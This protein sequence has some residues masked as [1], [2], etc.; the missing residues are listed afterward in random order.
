MD[1][2]RWNV[3]KCLRLPVAPGLLLGA[4]IGVVAVSTTVG[5]S[6]IPRMVVGSTSHGTVTPHGRAVGQSLPAAPDYGRAQF[7]D[8]VRAADGVAAPRQSA[9]TSRPSYLNSVSCLSSTWCMAV[10]AYSTASGTEST[11]VEHWN[12]SAWTILPSPSP[13]RGLHWLAGVSCVSASQCMAVGYYDDG[14]RTFSQTLI[15][16]WNGVEWSVV[17]S[18]STGDTT[19]LLFGVSCASASSC[20]AV[21]IRGANSTDTPLAEVWN[22][23]A[24]AVVD[25]PSP[26]DDAGFFGVSCSTSTSCV[27]VGRS[28]S[29][30]TQDPLIESWDGVQWTVATGGTTGGG[31]LHGVSCTSPSR[32]TAVGSTDY[33]ST[34]IESWNGSAWATNAS[35]SPGSWENTLSSVS[36]SLATS[37]MA[38]GDYASDSPVHRLLAT[39]FDGHTWADVSGERSGDVYGD[40]VGSVSC[41]A[42][43][44]C[45]AVGYH[46][47]ASGAQPLIEFWDGSYWSRM[48]SAS[49][50]V[51]V[52]P[53]VGMTATPSGA[54]YWLTDWAGNVSPHGQAPFYGSMSDR[55]LN[56]PVTHIVAAPDG[57]GYWLVASDGGIFSFGD[58]QFFGSM[59]GKPLNAPVVDLA[60]TSSGKGYWLVASDGGVFAFGDAVFSGS[61]GGRPLQR[62]VVGIAADK[63]TGG[64]WLVASDGGIFSFAAPFLGSTGG[65]ALNQPV[66]SMASTADGGG[67][68]STAEDGGVFSYGTASF[69]GSMGGQ[70]LSAP[71]VG[72]AADDATGGYW[73]VAS[74]GGVFSFGAPFLGAG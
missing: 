24:W 23:T 42:P 34:L 8:A 15:L 32:C 13:G 63:A 61:M 36:C 25:S 14:P 47:S 71:M 57:K 72:M 18:P 20:V 4:L 58:A 35:P 26:G 43:T 38:V 21:G 59:G 5:G 54:G 67:Y 12:G 27:A 70:S 11:L 53:F 65:V 73:L 7:S 74:D 52:A 19:D 48:A 49:F 2:H 62:P 66:V 40:N 30:D 29:K 22:G 46:E 41:T 50:G 17:T 55:A 16:S 60:P 33:Q 28:I 69:H 44:R 68:W 6:S 39:S 31:F 3:A 56:A 45:V 10:G 51:A 9:A 64:Y 1:P 37:C